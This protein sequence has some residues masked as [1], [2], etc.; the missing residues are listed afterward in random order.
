RY[1]AIDPI[2]PAV[3]TMAVVASVGAAFLSWRYV[4][5]PFRHLN[6]RAKIW[7]WSAAAGG[8]M[9]LASAALIVSH[10]FPQRFSPQ[11]VALNA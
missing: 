8:V 3:A 2:T 1:A 4:E 11:I 6:S 7:G 10:G 5:R 9:A